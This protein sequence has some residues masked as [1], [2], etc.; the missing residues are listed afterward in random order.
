MESVYLCLST[1]IF[2]KASLV[3]EAETSAARDVTRDLKEM[4][5]KWEAGEELSPELAG[6]DKQPKMSNQEELL[7]SEVPLISISLTEKFMNH[8]TSQISINFICW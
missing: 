4:S 5:P 2:T 3:T 6:S 8:L 1:Y 7:S